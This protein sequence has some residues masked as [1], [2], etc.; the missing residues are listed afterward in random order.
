MA[1]QVKGV[2]NMTYRLTLINLDTMK[3]A[4]RK[5]L[6]SWHWTQTD[7][8]QWRVVAKTQLD[9][10]QQEI[11]A[12][13]AKL[14]EATKDDEKIVEEVNHLLYISGAISREST[15]KQILVLLHAREEEIRKQT[16][17]NQTIEFVCS[18]CGY[19]STITG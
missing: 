12:Q 17:N 15:I 9:H 18:N 7:E 19:K 14:S 3:D 13:L 2:G 10:N 1:R 16:T 4:F 11:D 5:S 8:E 6:A